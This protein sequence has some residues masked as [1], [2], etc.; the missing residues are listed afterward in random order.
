MRPAR[1]PSAGGHF[2]NQGP[3]GKALCLCWLGVQFNRRDLLQTISSAILEDTQGE[4]KPRDDGSKRELG[5]PPCVE[6]PRD[7]SG[8]AHLVVDR[9]R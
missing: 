7:S 9:R 6:E 3:G 1:G 4:P 8:H 5:F 2:G